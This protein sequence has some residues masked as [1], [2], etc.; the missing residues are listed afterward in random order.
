[1]RSINCTLITDKF[2]TCLA[3][4]NKWRF[5]MN[6]VTSYN[7]KSYAAGGRIADTSDWSS[8]IDFLDFYLLVY[9]FDFTSFPYFY[10]LSAFE[11]D[12]SLLLLFDLSD[13][14]SSAFFLLFELF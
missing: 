8:T 9:F 10:F 3:V 13:F 11:G 14:V 1:M 7:L 6:A 2:L 5:V 4:V 12:L